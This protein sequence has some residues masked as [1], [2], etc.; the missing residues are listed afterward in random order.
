MN[1]WIKF[2]LISERSSTDKTRQAFIFPTNKTDRWL[3]VR[4][5]FLLSATV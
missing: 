5:L 3:A 2:I 4:N 1:T